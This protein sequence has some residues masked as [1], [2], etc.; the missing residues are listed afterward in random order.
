[1][2]TD[3][4]SQAGMK[5]EDLGDAPL[6]A[7]WMPAVEPP[8]GPLLVGR[9]KG[10]PRLGDRWITTSLLI[11]ID[12]ALT[13]ARTW[14][15]WYRIEH[16]MTCD[17]ITAARGRALRPEIL[18]IEDEDLAQHLADLRDQVAAMLRPLERRK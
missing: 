3:P 16:R 6:L 5:A 4:E 8:D 13:W 9:V 11:G 14:S 15:R 10:H 18:D 2:H 1:M 17:E 7:S 12:P